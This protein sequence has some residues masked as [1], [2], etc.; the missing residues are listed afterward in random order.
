MNLLTNVLDGAVSKPFNIIELDIEALFCFL[1]LF[2][3]ISIAK[4]PL[5]ELD[6][7]FVSFC[8]VMFLA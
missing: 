7:L 8:A 4:D 5:S 2:K 6:N 1:L 3:V